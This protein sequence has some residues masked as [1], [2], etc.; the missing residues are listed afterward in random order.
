MIKGRIAKVAIFFMAFIFVLYNV[1][2]VLSFKG[3][4]GILGMQYFFEQEEDSVD[5]LILGS[6]HAFEA[7]NT[8]VLFDSY[9]ISAYVLAGSAQPYWNTYY[10]LKEALKKQTPKVVILEA[11][12]ST[13]K[14]EYSDNSRIIKN[15]FGIKDI[16]TRTQSLKVSS[17]KEKW[18]DYLFRYRLWHS[19]YE[20]IS[21][22]DFSGY[23]ETPVHKYYKGFG[24]N[25]NTTSFTMPA[26]DEVRD[27]TP[28]TKKTEKYYCKI[29]DLCKEREI[30]IMVVVSPYNLS[31]EDQK[32]FN[33]S[34]SIAEDYGI[35]F[36]NFNSADYYQKMNLDFSTDLADGN[37]LNYRGNEKYTNIFAKELTAR[38]N[39]DDHRG[40]DK[41]NSWL[42]H[43]K[44][45]LRRVINYELTNTDSPEVFFKKLD[46][47]DEYT[48]VV[49]NLMNLEHSD[50]LQLLS[51]NKTLKENINLIQ[52]KSFCSFGNGNIINN[53][54]EI[55][56][57]YSQKFQ[58]NSVLSIS[59][60]FVMDE[61][62]RKFLSSLKWN[63]DEYID[64]ETGCY[65]FVYD[66]F[67]KSL[68]CV[69]KLIMDETRKCIFA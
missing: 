58:K 64:D 33:Y 4:D 7:I 59:R 12:A 8:G 34:K 41:Y 62:K 9:G 39:L 10:Y 2:S 27:E 26:V 25:F 32:I 67:E 54:D 31:E 18:D 28:M 55:T 43:S 69:R 22:S 60:Q 46:M 45:V 1:A 29:I 6:S 49:V 47:E 50:I 3:G 21:E 23:Y 65:I 36:I 57:E 16:F 35:P 19:R 24:I 44:D 53:S 38:Y 13:I 63:G 56:W 11:F 40:D 37:H 5:V 42:L 20:E 66:E 15:N 68:V 14:A 48:V 30:P 52:E 17:P 51:V 61:T